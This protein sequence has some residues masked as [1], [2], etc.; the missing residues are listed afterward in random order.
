MSKYYCGCDVG[1]TY[2]K[3]VI[4]DEENNIASSAIV[5]S[6]VDP[7]HSAKASIEEAMKNIDGLNSVE[8]LA[9]IIG[10]GYGRTQIDFAQENVSE[11]SCHAMGVHTIN[12][13]VR[14]IID[15]GGQD[16]KGISVDA[17]GSVKDFGMN[18]KCAAGTG[19][20]FELMARALDVDIEDFSELSLKSTKA[21]SITS[22]CSVFAETEVISLLSQ[23]KSTADIASGIQLSVAK[24]CFGMAK[25]V[26]M[27][28]EVTVS[29]GCAK[30]E[31]LIL[32]LEKVL[33]VKISRLSFDPQ[34]MG[35]LGAAVYANQKSKV[36]GM[37]LKY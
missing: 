35:A 14:T 19:R 6:K 30:N 1:S 33:R 36:K 21:I 37:K 24:R 15:I 11:I 13:K 2:A 18:D 27:L 16:V 10:T 28:E 23:K 5:R 34:L 9:Y 12:P 26:G 32:A 22:Q 25:S 17:D 7:S 4:L 29:G 20:F 8:D 3:C 31:G